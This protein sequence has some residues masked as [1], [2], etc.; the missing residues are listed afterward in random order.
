MESVIIPFGEWMPDQEGL[1]N[2]STHV[3]NVIPQGATYASVPGLDVMSDAI[4]SQA[5]SGAWALDDSGNYHLFAGCATKL[6][7]ISGVAWGDVSNAGGHSVTNWEFLK[8]GEQILAIGEGEPVQEY[9]MGTSSVF[10]DL[11]NAPTASC[12]AVVGDFVVLGGVG[13]DPTLV[14]WSGF[15]NATIWTPTPATQSDSQ[16]LLG[17]GTTIQKIVPQGNRGVIVCDRS[18]RALTYVGPPLIFRVDVVEED[19]GT[20]ARNSV[21]SNGPLI[22]YYG[23]DGFYQFSLG[24]GSINI[25]L[26][27]VDRFFRDDMDFSR[28][29]EM[30][31]GISRKYQ[32]A[33]WTYPS[34]STG[35]FRLLCYR[36][37]MKK[38]TIINAGLETVFDHA[39]VALS[40]E[41]LDSLYAT[42]DTATVSIDS[43]AIKGGLV[44]LAGFNSAHKLVTLTNTATP[45][46]A[47]LESAEFS[48][49]NGRRI[50]VSSIRPLVDASSTLAVGTRADYAS[51]FS[52]GAA[53]STNSIGEVN[54][55]ASGRHH[56]Y[57]MNLSERFNH[58]RGVEL[59]YRVGGRR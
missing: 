16:N 29:S 49:P 31:A 1:G 58:A 8:W 17:N 48:L 45:F 32:M 40:L 13:G 23:I 21:C 7:K 39:S 52:Y 6:Y 56:R 14:Q 24:A 2:S 43:D 18:I 57:K 50:D 55:R 20:L 34:L 4:A 26:E 41:D 27:K 5:F 25:G 59:F 19:R 28:I 54:I 30:R 44:S 10:A 37:G 12:G 46:A 35:D 3:I 9:T 15:N 42:L 51:A 33:V 22:F 53:R 38:W 11:T 47:T 36:W